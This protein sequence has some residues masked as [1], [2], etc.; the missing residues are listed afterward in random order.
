MYGGPG[1]LTAQCYP[2]EAVSRTKEKNK[3]QPAANNFSTF[4]SR[5]GRVTRTL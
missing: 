2:T 5:N 4:H 3:V 1:L